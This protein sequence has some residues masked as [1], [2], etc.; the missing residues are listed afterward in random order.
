MSSKLESLDAAAYSIS[1]AI[2]M[3]ACNLLVVSVNPLEGRY[4]QLFLQRASFLQLV[5]IAGFDDLD[6]HAHLF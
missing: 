2:S 1:N 4:L 6:T 5:N 3:L